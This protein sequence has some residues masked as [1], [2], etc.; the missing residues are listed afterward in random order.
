MAL[1]LMGNIRLWIVIFVIGILISLVFSRIYC[2]WMCPIYTLFRPINWIY[3]RAGVKRRKTPHIQRRNTLATIIVAVFVL[4]MIATQ[5]HV[6]KIPVFPLILVI[7]VVITLFFEEEFFHKYLCPFGI[8]L[9]VTS[10]ISRL[11][12]LV[13]GKECVNCY[14]CIRV[15]PN[16]ALSISGETG[17]TISRPDC[18]VCLRCQEVCPKDSFQYGRI[19]AQREETAKDQQTQTLR[20]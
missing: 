20:Q 16:G 3:A 12:M 18:L 19:A 6:I 5:L 8:I 13:R 17:I 7:G 15:C 9:G 1:F 11:G 4:V 10:R 14:R 2:G